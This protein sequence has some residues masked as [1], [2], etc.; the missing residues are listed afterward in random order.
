MIAVPA[1]DLRGGR[2]VQ[3]VGGRPTDERVS[4]PDPASVAQRWWDMGFNSLHVVDLD[5]ALDAGDNAR[6]VAEVLAASP[7]DTQVGG[8]VRTRDR[9]ETLLTLGASRVVVGTRAVDDRTWLERLAHTYPDRMVVAADVRGGI[10][11]RKGWT[12]ASAL[13]V[14]PFLTALA[15]LP[16]AGV[17]CTDVAREGRMEGID[18]TG[19]RAVVSA[20]PHPVQMSGGITN[21]DDLSAL[22]DAGVNAA[23]IGMALYTGHIDAEVVARTYGSKE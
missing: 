13:R 11:L 9:V 16:L 18:L 1:V 21:L 22:A 14:E 7:P 17:L 5:A 4:L 19:V 2:C 6:V 15:D 8:G 20:S 23:V 3:L 12:E 10:V